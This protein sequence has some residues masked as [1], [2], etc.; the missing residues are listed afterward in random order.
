[1]INFMVTEDGLEDQLLALTVAK[2]RP[3]L[4]EQK[5][6]QQLKLAKIAIQKEYEAYELGKQNI[7][8]AENIIAT[9]KNPLTN[10]IEKE[11]G[12][13]IVPQGKKLEFYMTI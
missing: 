4:E 2:E 5:A 3:D 12:E 8:D 13:K 11:N 9:P 7:E 10:Q 1:M 6:N